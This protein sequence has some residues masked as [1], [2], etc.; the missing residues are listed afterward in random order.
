MYK[1]LSKIKILSGFNAG[2]RIGV[3]KRIKK[4]QELN[5]GLINKRLK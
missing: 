3:V 5:P 4:D 1:N 2:F